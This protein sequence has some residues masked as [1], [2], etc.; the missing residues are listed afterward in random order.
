MG[1]MGVM[2]MKE[3]CSP[4]LSWD[5]L[6]SSPLNGCRGYVLAVGGRRLRQRRRWRRVRVRRVRVRGMG[7]G[8][9]QCS[10]SISWHV[11]VS[12]LHHVG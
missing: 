2:R 10:V 8:E 6:E 7:M 3:E 9:E 12:S 4:V 11:L 5:M 1:V